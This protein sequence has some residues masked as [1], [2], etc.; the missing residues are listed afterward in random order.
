MDVALQG[1]RWW[2]L[3]ILDGY[4]RTMLAGAVAPAEASW[5]ALTVLHTACQRYG[6]PVHLISDRGGAFTSD[7]FAGVCR[8]LALDHQT[9]VS[10]QGQSYMHLMVTV[11]GRITPSTSASKPCVPLLRHTAPQ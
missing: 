2:S 9:M 3:M 4:S 11:D 5:V 7:A 8:R 10:T 6:I 1:H